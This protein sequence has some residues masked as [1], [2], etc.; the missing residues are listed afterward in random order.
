MKTY[1]ILD[2]A[3]RSVP[4]VILVAGWLAGWPGLLAWQAGLAGWLA[5][6]EGWPG[7]LAGLA[8]WP[9][10][11]AGL[12]G[13]L[14]WLAALQDSQGV[15]GGWQPLHKSTNLSDISDMLL[16]VNTR[17]RSDTKKRQ[18]KF[19]RIFGD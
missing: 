4:G 6:L 11:L 3:T 2:S 5:G 14:A 10:W 13:W 18:N 19:Y 7:W 8:G 16:R 9:G 1:S 15:L 12:A 17:N